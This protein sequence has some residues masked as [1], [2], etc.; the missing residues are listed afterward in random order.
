MVTRSRIAGPVGFALWILVALAGLQWGRS[1]APAPIPSAVP[2]AFLPFLDRPLGL[3][4]RERAG[5]APRTRS[6]GGFDPDALITR[7]GPAVDR[8]AALVTGPTLPSLGGSPSAT[9][10][11][12]LVDLLVAR[13]ARRSARGRAS[14][15]VTDW[16]AALRIARCVWHGAADGPVVTAMLMGAR[17]EARILDA[18]PELLGEGHVVFDQAL[19][20]VAELRRRDREIP[21]VRAVLE[22]ERRRARAVLDEHASTGRWPEE[23][24]A[25]RWLRWWI[26]GG[27]TARKATLRR[28]GTDVDAAIARQ[29]QAIETGAPQPARRADGAGSSSWTYPMLWVGWYESLAGLLDADRGQDLALRAILGAYLP[30]IEVIVGTR[31]ALEGDARWIEETCARLAGVRR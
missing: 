2:S 4:A 14:E 7:F 1:R 24:G 15:G 22:A 21:G 28:L 27:E 31:G 17:L 25:A 18:L 30:R 16:I 26:P 13:G 3:T 20:L 5:L 8:A 9:A 12:D 10:A 6:P 11:A 23:F 29:I 19:R